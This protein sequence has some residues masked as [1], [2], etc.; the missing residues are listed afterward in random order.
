MPEKK[1]KTVSEDSPRDLEGISP[2]W[3]A[4]GDLA[5]HHP[6]LQRMCWKALLVADT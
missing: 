6:T 2:L 4:S 5:A 3:V 1:T